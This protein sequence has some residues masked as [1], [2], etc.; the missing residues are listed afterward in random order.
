MPRARDNGYG[1]R[2]PTSTARWLASPG[3]GRTAYGSTLAALLFWLLASVPSAAW[4]VDALQSWNEGPTRSRIVEFV[5]RVTDPTSADFVPPAERIAVFDNDG[6]LW[7][8]KPVY[9]QLLFALDRIKALAPA[10]P[11]WKDT[12]PFKSVLAGDMAGLAAGGQRAILELVMASHAGNTAEEF[13]AIVSEWLA[14]AR[15]PQ[16]GRRY[17]EMIYQPMRELLDYLRANGFKTFIVSGGGIEFM[18]PWVERVYGI[19]PEQVVGSS[20]RTKYELR[21]GRPAIVR[22]P[23]VDFIDDKAGKPVGIHK[24]IGR[25][26]ILA[27]GNSDGDF[28]MLEYVTGGRGP[29]L[30][31]IVHHD[32]ADREYAYDRDSSVGRLA[33]GLDEAPRRGWK[34]ISMKRDW[35]RIY[36]DARR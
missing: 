23:E 16:T 11:E 4:A 28:E 32:D 10:H 36:P 19:P 27:V 8:E 2:R 9:F 1:L 31:L 14:T 25:R 26:P 6:T 18:R 17:D 24:F 22:L 30:G 7:S 20:I 3:T 5:Q 33:R 35:R 21:D 15:H 34:M 13:E 29:A 12:E